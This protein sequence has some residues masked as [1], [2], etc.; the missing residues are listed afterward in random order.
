MKRILGLTVVVGSFVSL[1]AAQVAAPS[2]PPRS[3]AIKRTLVEA[4]PATGAAAVFLADLSKARRVDAIDDAA[5]GDAMR[6]SAAEIDASMQPAVSEAPS[7][8]PAWAL[9]V[10][11]VRADWEKSLSCE[12]MKE[13]KKALEVMLRIGDIKLRVDGP[14]S[15]FSGPWRSELLEWRNKFEER[16]KAYDSWMSRNVPSCTA[17]LRWASRLKE[18]GTFAMVYRF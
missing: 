14:T 12:Q 5:V 4:S 3:A 10:K 18:D 2:T 9:V 15:A 8:L 11:S 6:R 16:I 13:C 17:S 7:G 1:Q